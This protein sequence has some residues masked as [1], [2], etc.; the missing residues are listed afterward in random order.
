[1][2]N[3]YETAAVFLFPSLDEGFGIPVLEAMAAGIPVITSN[4]SALAEVAGNAAVL[5]DPT[6]TSQIVSA[7][8]QLTGVEA[9]RKQ[10]IEAGLARVQ[11]FSSE[12]MIDSTYRVY[13]EALG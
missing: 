1:L 10:F 11:Y 4:R 6:D 7:L 12:S 8:R 13:R 9:L 5:V 3:L 2:R